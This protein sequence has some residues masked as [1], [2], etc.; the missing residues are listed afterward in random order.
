LDNGNRNQNE[1]LVDLPD[2]GENGQP[3]EKKNQKEID[4]ARESTL[5]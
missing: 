5:A 4:P 3:D 2:G 1:L